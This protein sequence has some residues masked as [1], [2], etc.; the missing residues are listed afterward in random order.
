MATPCLKLKVNIMLGLSKQVS[1]K[2]KLWDR[3]RKL[4]IDLFQEA[5]VSSRMEAYWHV[6]DLLR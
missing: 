2:S 6:T 5:S 3:E 1:Q 4:C